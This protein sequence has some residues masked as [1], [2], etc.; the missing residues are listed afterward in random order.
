MD[1]ILY[2]VTIT[3]KDLE[4]MCRATVWQFGYNTPFVLGTSLPPVLSIACRIARA[5][6][7]K[8]DS[9]LHRRK[10]PV[11]KDSLRLTDGGHFRLSAHQRAM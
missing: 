11:V 10:S 1:R 7:L 5:R 6:A 3:E 8:A 2:D 9:A 4:R